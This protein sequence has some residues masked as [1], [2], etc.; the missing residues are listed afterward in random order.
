MSG[1]AEAAQGSWLRSLLFNIG[2]FGWTTLVVV[3]GLVLLP[4]PW[5]W[6]HRLG[7]LWCRGTLVLLR[8]IVGLRHRIEGKENLLREPAI[9][10]SKHQSTWDTLIFAMLLPD[11]AYVL[12]RELYRV[13]LF[14]QLLAR[15]R[16]IAIDRSAGGSALRRMLASAKRA[17]GD[18]RAIVIFPE[19][20]RTAPGESG[21][22]QPGTAALYQSLGVPVV[23]VA[24]D[25]GLYWGRRQFVKR[26][27]TITIR[28]LPPIAPG[29]ERREF[30]ATLEG[31]IE[32][33][34]RALD[35]R[36]DPLRRI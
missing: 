29:L 14:G 5:P 22:Y 21:R 32:T 15:S 6:M 23:P 34:C 18:G 7:R 36:P 2:F 17:I 27:G 26:P 4:L 3:G 9:Y 19:G 16:P 31:R 25:S 13:P 1:E 12:K 20:T 30:M 10:A 11:C 8:L 28:F 33:A 35:G 24:L